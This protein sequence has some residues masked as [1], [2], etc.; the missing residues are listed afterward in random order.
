MEIHPLRSSQFSFQLKHSL[1]PHSKL[2]NDARRNLYED[3]LFLQVEEQKQ[4]VR[5]MKDE[6]VSE[7][8]ERR[9]FDWKLLAAH[10][11][12]HQSNMFEIIKQAKNTGNTVAKKQS[13]RHTKTCY[14][15]YQ[16]MFLLVNLI[17][18][19][20]YFFLNVHH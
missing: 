20:L 10:Y 3:Y 14:L 9:T 8:C 2:T 16:Y 19:I 11:C 12:I 5:D 6:V 13:G 7:I 18:K 4:R 15:Y 17:L 1:K